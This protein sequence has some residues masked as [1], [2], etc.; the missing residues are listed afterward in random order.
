MKC[1]VAMLLTGLILALCASLYFR[2][3]IIALQHCLCSASQT[4]LSAAANQ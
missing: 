2:D 3:D 1:Y 4:H